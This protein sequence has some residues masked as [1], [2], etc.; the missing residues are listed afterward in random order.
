M[1]GKKKETEKKKRSKLPKLLSGRQ[2]ETGLEEFPASFLRATLSWRARAGKNQR[3]EA[4]TEEDIALNVQKP[5]E[6]CRWEFR[7]TAERAF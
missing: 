7:I 6:G 1:K 3:H 2:V 5:V 4:A